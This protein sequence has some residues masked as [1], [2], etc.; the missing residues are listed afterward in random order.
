MIKSISTLGNEIWVN[1][2]NINIMFVIEN[3]TYITFIMQ[4]REV[5]HTIN[6]TP[7]QINVMFKQEQ[8]L[9][10]PIRIFTLY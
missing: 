5:T 3:K 2:K 6:E 1:P 9:Y 10:N 7:E 4:G 8:E